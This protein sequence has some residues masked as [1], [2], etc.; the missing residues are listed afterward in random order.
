[1]AKIA[2]KILAISSQVASGHVGLSAMVP[3]WQALGHE[4]IALPT[5]VLSNHPGRQ[6]THG[7][8]IEAEMLAAMVATLDAN[9]RLEGVDA[10]LTGYLPSAAHAV[11]ARDVVRRC[12]RKS[13]RTVYLCD[14]VLGDDPKGL[15]IDPLA[16]AVI[17]NELVPLADIVTPNRFE[18]AW[19]TGLRVDGV[20]GAIA[21]ARALG[22]PLTVGTSIPADGA[23]L[24][25][26]AVGRERVDQL[27]VARREDAPN[28]TGDLLAALIL[29]GILAGRLR[30][31]P[32]DACG[33]AAA[34]AVIDQI[35]EA[36]VGR[37]EMDLVGAIAGWHR[38][39]K[40][41][42]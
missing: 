33:L 17:G 19:L 35:L 26:V 24:A 8:R 16:A 14:P 11:M 12:V 31:D 27:F 41:P 21:A 37:A 36:S 13:A 39:G 20:E 6:P 22:R 38:A 34:V 42:I 28:G 7:V 30:G 9:G 29:D 15:Y 32:T 18:L 25:T 40:A 23:R 2:Q 5:V 1:M 4:V 10:V 3:A